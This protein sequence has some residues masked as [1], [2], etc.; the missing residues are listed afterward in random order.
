MYRKHGAYYYVKAGKW[1]RLAKDL[2]GALQA[3]ANLLEASDKGRGMVE[4]IDRVLT[5][6]EPNLK[7]NTIAQYRIAARKLKP[8]LLEFAP[9]QVLP[10]HIAEIKMHFADTPNMANRLLSFLRTVFAYALEWRLVDS[11]PCIGVRRHKEG[12]RDRYITNAEFLAI[13]SAA[14]HKAIPIIMDLCYLTGQRIG[15]VLAI[16]NEDI[17]EAGIAFKQKKTG[18]LLLVRMTPALSQTIAL[19]REHHPEDRRASTLLYTRGFKIYSYGTI[20][21]AFDRAR[22]AAGLQDITIHDIRAKSGTDAEEEGKDP[23]RLLGH[24]NPQMTKRYLRGRKAKLVEGP[25][26]V[27][28][29]G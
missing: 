11:N 18:S 8:I 13:R 7:P 14:R 12:K 4:L 20:K 21:D 6:I 17:S 28:E 27:K 10:R 1:T 29:V 2:P 24:S 22:Q 23:Q 15:D 3:Y 9:E 16:R 5:H 19:A 25:A 26:M